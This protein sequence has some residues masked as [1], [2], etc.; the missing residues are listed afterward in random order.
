[1]NLWTVQV[2]LTYWIQRLTFVLAADLLGSNGV[3]SSS[4]H[5]KIAD[6]HTP[7]FTKCLV[8]SNH[9]FQTEAFIQNERDLVK[10]FKR[11]ETA[12]SR[13]PYVSWCNLS[14]IHHVNQMH[15]KLKSLEFSL[16][17][18]KNDVKPKQKAATVPVMCVVNLP[19]IHTTGAVYLAGVGFVS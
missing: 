19:R 11:T 8:K 14:A 2:N 6:K 5:V 4:G 12:V 10:C 13:L 15:T 16:S 18:F 9:I 17:D 7:R 1:M 3:N